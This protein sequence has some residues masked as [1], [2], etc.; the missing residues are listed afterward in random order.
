[1]RGYMKHRRPFP[2]R[3]R[4]VGRAFFVNFRT[5]NQGRAVKGNDSQH[6]V[7]PPEQRQQPRRRQPLKRTYKCRFFLYKS[8]GAAYVSH[9]GGEFENYTF[10]KGILRWKR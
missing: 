5:Q 10:N 1:M 4:F 7:A 2:E 9:D 8:Q 6:F 3:G